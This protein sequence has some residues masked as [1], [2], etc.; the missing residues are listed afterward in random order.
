MKKRIYRFHGKYK[1]FVLMAIW[2]CLV[3][4]RNSH[5]LATRLVFSMLDGMFAGGI[6]AR[7]ALGMGAESLIK[8]AYIRGKVAGIDFTVN[9]VGVTG[10]KQADII[11][12]ELKSLR[13]ETD[14]V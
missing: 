1:V 10:T 2:V 12:A 6:I 14:E 9:T 8:L 4:G 7:Y 3:I 13:S 11:N 5:V